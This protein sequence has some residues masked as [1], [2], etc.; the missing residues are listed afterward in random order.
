MCSILA[1]DPDD[2]VMLNDE[3]YFHLNGYVTKQKCRYCPTDNPRELHQKL[4]HSEKV[5][6]WRE[7]ERKVTVPYGPLQNVTK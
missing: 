5:I 6:V 7:E 1:N 2:V 3:T 4:V